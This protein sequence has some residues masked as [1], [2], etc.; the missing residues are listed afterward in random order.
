MNKKDIEKIA[1]EW[2]WTVE[3]L[4]ACLEVGGAGI[5]NLSA[6]QCAAEIIKK[7]VKKG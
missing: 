7:I 1:D 4:I 3:R 6:G 5:S 2:G